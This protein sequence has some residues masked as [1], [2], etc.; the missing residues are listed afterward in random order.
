MRGQKCG[1][2][3]QDY[4]VENHMGY[5]LD[6][7]NRKRNGKLTPEDV[8]AGSRKKVWW[9]QPYDDE[10][11]GKHFDFEW[12]AEINSRVKGAGCPYLS[13]QKVWRGFNDLATTHPELAAQWH[14]IKNGT[15]TP[16][17]VSAGS[18]KKIWWLLHYDD[19]ETGKHFNFSWQARITGRVSGLGCP[20]LSGQKVWKGFND[21]ETYCKEN[22]RLDI[23]NWWD[24][25]KNGDLKPSDVT[26]K[27][28][29]KVW[30]IKDGK[31]CFRQIT[32]VMR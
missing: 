5:L 29:R 11:M 6:E 15:L 16:E 20:Y 7:W 13:G 25:E 24:Y 9:L 14:P 21:L 28:G 26:V 17:D 3:L 19:K 4:C 10:K 22:G 2:S 1:I 31:S 23:L 18:Q 8:T 30:W 32:S 12:Q 27:S